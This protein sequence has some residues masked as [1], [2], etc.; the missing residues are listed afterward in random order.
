MNSFLALRTLHM[1][2]VA[3]SLTG[4]LVRGVMRAVK[5]ALLQTRVARVVPHVIDTVLLAS[6]VCLATL[7]GFAANANWLLPKIG[8]LFVYVLLGSVALKY[9]RRRL[10]CVTSW[11]GAIFVFAFIVSVARTH[12]PLGFFAFL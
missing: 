4:F 11:L 2:C 3:L 9:G 7:V 12:Q 10:V 1:T 5:P 8:G 6:A